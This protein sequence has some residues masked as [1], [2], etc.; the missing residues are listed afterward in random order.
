M[1]INIVDIVL[2]GI[3][4]LA[5]MYGWRWGTINVVARVG[6]L[7]LAYQT[8]RAYSS[9]ITAYLVDILPFLSASASE[10][11]TADG[12]QQL[13]AFLSFFIDTESITNKLLNMIVF[14]VIFVVVNWAIRKIAYT[15]TGIFGRGLLGKINRV[16]GAF[17]SLVL[18]VVIITILNDIVLPACINMGFGTKV[19]EFLHSS[20]LIMPLIKE[21]PTML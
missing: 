3:L 12:G 5:I 19:V 18:M 20:G 9:F 6:A 2:I 14:I 10:E 1:G 17:I 13:F 7:V 8:A 11:G 15:L 4:L 21:L 16:L